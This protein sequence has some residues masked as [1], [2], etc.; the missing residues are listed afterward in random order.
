MYST[1]EHA[2]DQDPEQYRNP[3]ENCCLDGA[4]DGTCA[5][6]GCELMAK[7]NIGVCRLIVNAILQFVG[8]GFRIG[9][10][11]QVLASHLP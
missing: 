9:I 2:A 4:V 1:K 11:A 10:D 8:R 6:D 3:A 7:D 5:G